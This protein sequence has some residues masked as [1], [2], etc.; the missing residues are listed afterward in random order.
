MRFPEQYATLRQ[1]LVVLPDTDGE[2]AWLV[3][4]SDPFHPVVQ[5]FSSI[6]AAEAA[7]SEQVYR[8]LCSLATKAV[9]ETSA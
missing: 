1:Q 7:S 6:A 3:D 5:G 4:L 2:R 9:C 8:R